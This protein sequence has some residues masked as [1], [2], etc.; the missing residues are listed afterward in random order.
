M[1]DGLPQPQR[2]LALLTICIAIGMSVIDSAI[3]NVAL[4]TLSADF[5]VPP[6]HAIW[7][8][9]AYQLAITVSLLPL[10]SLGDILG[11]RTI[12]RMGIVLFTLASVACGLS[13]SL[14]TLTLARV[15]QGFGAAGVMSIN[16]ALVRAVYPKASLGAGV[17]NVAMVVAVCSAAGPSIGAAILAI[18][19]WRWL[20]FVNGPLGLIASVLA[21][22]VSAAYAETRR[23]TRRP[24][25][26]SQRGDVRPADL[27]RG[28]ARRA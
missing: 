14:L 1:S 22:R 17:S 21:F 12:Y 6:E 18:A 3:V 27:R 24:E 15:V 5:A 25:R 2:T 13:N 19:P 7:V 23:T 9:N 8:V 16:I 26:A 20:F 10:A 28:L 4:P 11:Y